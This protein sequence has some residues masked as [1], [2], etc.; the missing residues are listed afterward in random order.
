MTMQDINVPRLVICRRQLHLYLLCRMVE[1]V[2]LALSNI[3]FPYR[4]GGIV[5]RT[6]CCQS[7]SLCFNAHSEHLFMK[8]NKYGYDNI[9]V[10]SLSN[11]FY[12]HCFNRLS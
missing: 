12:L 11:G 3:I 1:G 6:L 10:L 7:L 4:I 9:F 5:V 8:I 2:V